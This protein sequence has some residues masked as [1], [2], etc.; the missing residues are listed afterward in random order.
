MNYSK[1]FFS[2]FSISLATTIQV[3]SNN[4]N[5]RPNIILIISDDQ[6]YADYGAYNQA[7]DI[8]TPNL[9][10]IVK[11]GVCFTN[12]YASAPIS[13]ASRAA[14]ITGA[15]QQR[16]GTY[17]YG[18]NIFPKSRKTI[19]EYLKQVGYHCV[20]VGKNHYAQ[21]LDNNRRVK[22]ATQDR[23]F[24]LNHGYHDF[25]G[26]CAHRHDYFKLKKSDNW[27]EGE[28]DDRMSQFGALW[29]NKVKRS[30]E[31]YS[32]NVFADEAVK[33]IENEKDKPLFLEL[34]FNAVH[35]PIYQVPQ[36]Y[37]DKFGIKKFPEWNPKHES[38]MQYHARTCWRLK[39]DPDG[40][41]RYLANLACLDDNVG[42]VIEALKKSGKFENTLII[43]VS[44]NGG[45]QNTY[46]N[47]GVL[48]G[49]KYILKEGGIR[50]VFSMCWP[51][52][53]KPKMKIDK[54]ISHMDILPTCLNAAGINSDN[55]NQ[56][57]GTNL[58]PLINGQKQQIHESLIWDTGN[59]WAVRKG[60]WKLHKVKKDNHFRTI[61]LDSGLF[62][63]NLQVDVSEQDN[64]I[65]EFPK[66]V[67]QLTTE[68]HNWK[69][70][71]K[72]Q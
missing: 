5:I 41:E 38:F 14:I 1:Y 42:K 70:M 33:F 11:A 53:F 67:E 54:V 59:E 44:D 61:H 32:T 55:E 24:P 8:Q 62:L 50:T 6:G 40:R 3:K 10:K 64:L 15:Y 60:S 7:T 18:G 17:Y 69:T 66:L 63:Y 22:D 12:A 68:Y 20:K 56:I 26:F 25:I 36:K 2:C 71:I 49:H 39:E 47:N 51:N 29:H 13:N 34:S 43:Y 65:E 30:F 21:I 4:E 9:D 57:D 27:V 37:L 48:N 31:G 52:K 19:P 16:W 35:H 28:D 45:S 58:F 46:A 23:E 72:T